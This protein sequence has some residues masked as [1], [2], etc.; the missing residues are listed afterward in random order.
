MGLTWLLVFIC[1]GA[2]LNVWSINRM[3]EAVKGI[4]ERDYSDVVNVLLG[5]NAAIVL[6]VFVI[7]YSFGHV[8]SYLTLV[9]A[10]LGR[11]IKGIWYYDDDRYPD[12]DTFKSEVWKEPK[13]VYPIIFGLAIILGVICLQRDLSKL[14]FV[15]YFG[16]GA[17]LYAVLV[18]IIECH[19]Y[20]ERF[21]GN[22]DINWYDIT[23]AFTSDLEFF[24]VMSTLFNAFSCHTSVYP[25]FDTF[26]NCEGDV[27]MMNK[28]VIY[29][30][31]IEFL[32]FVSIY[33]IY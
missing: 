17:N 33:I 31:I 29:S 12:F 24:N 19:S 5:K 10:L 7:I 26:R 2:L 16:M 15:G 30:C 4:S 9:Y 13:Y 23:K 20:Y 27:D 25:T 22:D 6:N 14:N 21:K 18:V 3:V 8:M 1:I 11:F 28:A 32:F